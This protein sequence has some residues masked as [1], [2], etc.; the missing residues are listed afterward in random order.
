M[1]PSLCK[2]NM[3]VIMMVGYEID[4]QFHWVVFS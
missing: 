2:D 1:I 3:D 4:T